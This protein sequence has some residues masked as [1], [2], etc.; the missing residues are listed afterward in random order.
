MHEDRLHEHF[1]PCLKQEY[2]TPHWNQ[3]QHLQYVYTSWSCNNMLN[4]HNFYRKLQYNSPLNC[5][6]VLK[7]I[8]KIVYQCCILRLKIIRDKSQLSFI[9]SEAVLSKKTTTPLLD[10]KEWSPGKLWFGLLINITNTWAFVQ[11]IKRLC[12]LIYAQSH[13]QKQ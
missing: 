9:A 6:E 13:Q 1:N 12:K 11:N 10:S 4:F 3:K 7:M 8:S 5:C 2:L